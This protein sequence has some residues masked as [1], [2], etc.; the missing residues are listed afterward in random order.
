MTEK[1]H[2]HTHDSNCLRTLRLQTSKRH[3]LVTNRR[4]AKTLNTQLSTRQLGALDASRDLLERNLSGLVGAGMLRLDVDAERAEATVVRGTET[5]HG[6]VL[7]GLEQGITNLLGSLNTG[8][9]R[10]DDANEA[11]LFLMSESASSGYSG[12]DDVLT[13]L[14]HSVCIRTRVLATE[15]VDAGF[16]SF[17]GQLDKEISG[18]HLEHAGQTLWE[19]FVSGIR[20]E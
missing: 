8:I 9:E 20:E 3:G 10:V 11:Y 18:V 5:L 6:D 13:Y 19:Q 17:S 7:G 14:W 16:V 1:K 12:G 4:V 2:T 15:I